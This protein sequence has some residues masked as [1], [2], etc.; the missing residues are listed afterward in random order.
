M[1]TLVAMAYP[2]GVTRVV[3]IVLLV[4]AS[5]C[6]WTHI[7]QADRATPGIRARGNDPWTDWKDSTRTMFLW[8]AIRQDLPVVNCYLGDN[9]PT[10]I[11]EVRARK[12]VGQW[13]LTILTL[14]AVDPVTYGWRC[15][16]PP[17]RGGTLGV[18]GVP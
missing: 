5:G 13:L 2:R 17:A 3:S 6:S 15:Q 16:R 8:G 11:H 4:V 18:G 7:Y 14:G 9:T 1:R 10:G 12:N